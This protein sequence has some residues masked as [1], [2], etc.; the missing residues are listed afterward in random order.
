MSSGLFYQLL[1]GYSGVRRIS[2]LG[3]V[4]KQSADVISRSLGRRIAELREGRAWTQ[5]AFADRLGV[6]LKYVQR[7]E[8]GSENLTIVTMVHVANALGAKVASL[9]EK[10]SSVARR[11][12]GRPRKAA[13]AESK[14]TQQT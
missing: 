2:T 8:A 12:P 11:G 5:Q 7:L 10:P 4:A 14:R 13:P 9:F 1:R 3:L 6:T